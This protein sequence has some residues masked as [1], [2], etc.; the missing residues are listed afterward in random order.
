MLTVLIAVWALTSASYFWP[1]W[2]LLL[3][4]LA[5]AIHGWFVLLGEH[6]EWVGGAFRNRASPATPASRSRPSCT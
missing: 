2:V 3:L 6:P 1:M 4:A 5:L